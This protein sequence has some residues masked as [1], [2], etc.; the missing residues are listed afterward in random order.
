MALRRFTIEMP[1]DVLVQ[2]GVVPRVF[3]DHN[4]SVEILRVYAFQP[5]ERLLLVRPPKR[6]ASHRGRTSRGSRQSPPSIS[7]ERFRNPPG[8]GW[9]KRVHLAPEATQPRRPGGSRGGVRGGRDADDAERHRA[10]GRY[11]LVPRG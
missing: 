4:E 10:G 9:R 3:F 6:P 5:R 7:P 2:Q 1:S 8:G 11:A